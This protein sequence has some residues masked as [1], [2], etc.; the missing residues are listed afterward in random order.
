MMKKKILLGIVAAAILVGLVG[1][2]ILYNFGFRQRFEVVSAANIK[3]YLDAGLT[4]ELQPQQG[5]MLT[6]DTITDTGPQH[7]TIYIKNTG[8]GNITLQFDYRRDQIPQGW[9]QS[10]DYDGSN[11]VQNDNVTVTITLTLPSTIG[12]GTYECDSWITATPV[13]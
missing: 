13:P 8:I 1:A 9:S 6:W 4:Q 10:W 12:A 11:V 5:N 2:V 7:K 3:V